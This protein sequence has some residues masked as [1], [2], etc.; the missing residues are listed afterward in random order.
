MVCG[1]S[2]MGWGIHCCCCV[3][4]GFSVLVGDFEGV[5]DFFLPLSFWVVYLLS[6]F[7]FRAYAYYTRIGI[8]RQTDRRI[9]TL[10][11][12]YPARYLSVLYTQVVG[13]HEAPH[14]TTACA[15]ILIVAMPM[16]HVQPRAFLLPQQ[17]RSK[18]LFMRFFSASTLFL[19]FSFFTLGTSRF[20][21]IA[22]IT[23]RRAPSR[24]D[25]NTSCLPPAPQNGRKADLTGRWSQQSPALILLV[26]QQDQPLREAD[27]W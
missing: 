1:H 11:P 20:T 10:L 3:G 6:L 26:R 17:F 15:S 23:S 22:L 7:L 5:P 9:N 8:G 16:L 14:D 13:T 21:S 2:R 24:F 25:H 12:I 18:C 27:G 4:R 19:F